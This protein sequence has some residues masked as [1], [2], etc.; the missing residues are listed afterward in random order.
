MP[1]TAGLEPRRSSDFNNKDWWTK[2]EVGQPVLKIENIPIEHIGTDPAQ[3]ADM[4]NRTV[5]LP[6]NLGIDKSDF[7]DAL[8]RLVEKTVNYIYDQRKL[9]RQDSGTT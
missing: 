5:A 4:M 8:R 1:P 9:R 7:A 3:A 6:A 2:N